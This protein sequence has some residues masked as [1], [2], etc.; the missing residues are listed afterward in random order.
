VSAALS[1]LTK[2]QKTSSA[3]TRSPTILFT[4]TRPVAHKDDNLLLACLPHVTPPDQATL[5]SEPR[6]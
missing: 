1:G 5:R 2:T 3:I 4:C 6:R